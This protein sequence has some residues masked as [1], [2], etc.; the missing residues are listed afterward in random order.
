V[1]R[2]EQHDLV[3][4]AGQPQPGQRFLGAAS[5]QA[6]DLMSVSSLKG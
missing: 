6:V 2:V 5:E 1:R 4:V 3:A